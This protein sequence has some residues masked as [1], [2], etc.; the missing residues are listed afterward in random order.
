MDLLSLPAVPTAA[1]AI[2]NRIITDCS[3]LLRLQYDTEELYSI[4]A[5]RVE[6][7]HTLRSVQ[8]YSQRCVRLNYQV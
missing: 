6:S 3:L 1:N 5:G 2:Q 7:Q 8:H 4:K